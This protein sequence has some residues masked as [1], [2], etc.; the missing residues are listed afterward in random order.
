MHLQNITACTGLHADSHEKITHY[1]I[2][3][4]VECLCKYRWHLTNGMRLS[5]PSNALMATYKLCVHE[6]VTLSYLHVI[7]SHEETS[8]TFS[9]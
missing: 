9:V 3:T 1:H 5:R 8:T 7:F 4:G 2:Q 6:Q